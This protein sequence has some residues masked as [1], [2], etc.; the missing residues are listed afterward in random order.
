MKTDPV[1]PKKS[2]GQNFLVDQNIARKIVAALELQPDDRVLEIGPGCGA[3]TPF[4]LPRV[5][6]YL[7]VELD[8]ALVQRLQAGFG[9][10]P[11]FHLILDDFLKIDF[12]TALPTVKKTKIVGNIPYHITS[13]VIFKVIEQRQF[14]K[15]MTLM[16]QLEVAER[17]VSAPGSKLFGILSVLSQTFAVPKL[18][19]T[20]SPKVFFP[21]PKVTSAVV[22][23]D[24][25]NPVRYNVADETGF[26]RFVKN[27]FQFRRKMLRKSLRHFYGEELD[28]TAAQIDLSRRPE[29]L[30][31]SEFISLW[32]IISRSIS[33]P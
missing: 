14:F 1:I 23:W 30:E 32:G 29:S 22:Q 3:L 27:L 33:Q 9:N 7:G 24:F 26:M 18:L 13:G 6:T 17:I 28:F 25:S 2:L 11:G 15:N 8:R 4:I 10:E 12:A 20:V 31:I 5:E 21:R 16:I 19:F